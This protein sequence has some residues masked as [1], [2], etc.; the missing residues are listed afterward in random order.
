MTRFIRLIAAV[1]LSIAAPNI[2]YAKCDPEEIIFRFSHT[3]GIRLH[4]RGLTV[5]LLQIRVNAELNEE[6]CMEVYP[7]SILY[8]DTHVLK[9]VQN[10]D[11]QFAAPPTGVFEELAPSLRIMNLPYLF[12]N[13]DAFLEFEDDT[14][15]QRV[16]EELAVHDLKFLAFWHNGF[17]Q[18]I[19]KESIANPNDLRGKRV[20]SSNSLVNQFAFE[21]IGAQVETSSVLE[22]PSVIAQSEV[23]AHE[24]TWS[25]IYDME[26]DRVANQVLET[27]H[28]ILEYVL[29]TKK[30]WYDTLPAKTRG[31]LEDILAQVTRERNKTIFHLNNVAR[32]KL[33]E[34][35]TVEIADQSE[36]RHRWAFEMQPVRSMLSDEIPIELMMKINEINARN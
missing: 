9:A 24:N 25:N 20:L 19:S 34:A 18:I 3:N 21:L 22:V 6:A 23:F 2:V 1:L 5:E 29:V 11:I 12:K 15:K 7:N 16:A 32:R 26:I 30:S 8:R 36:E 17:R 33:L 13:I 35:Q 4:P 28:S 27:N 31:K 10:G 14:F